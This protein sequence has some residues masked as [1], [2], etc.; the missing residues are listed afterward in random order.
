MTREALNRLDKKI[1]RTNSIIEF[2]ETLEG[3]NIPFFGW[4]TAQSSRDKLH[5]L[6]EKRLDLLTKITYYYE[7]KK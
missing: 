5:R 3:R 2:Y 7:T 6:E 1:K 4:R